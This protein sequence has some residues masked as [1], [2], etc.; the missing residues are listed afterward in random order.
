[1]LYDGQWDYTDTNPYVDMW[2]AVSYNTTN[3]TYSNG[4]IWIVYS[5]CWEPTIY[6]EYFNN[7]SYGTLYLNGTYIFTDIYNF[8]N[9]GVQNWYSTD[10]STSGNSSSNWYWDGYGWTYNYTS[11][12]D[13]SST[14]NS[15]GSSST[16]GSNYI[17]YDSNGLY[18]C[19]NTT[20]NGSS[21]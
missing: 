11:P 20:T 6:N 10:N 13:N 9:W 7:G 18:P 14:V 3:G 4:S 15:G 19:P 16:G 2:N 21:S 1:M 8:D 5:Y 12:S 17:C